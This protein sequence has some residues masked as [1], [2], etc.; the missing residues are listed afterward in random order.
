MW[1]LTQDKYTG[2]WATQIHTEQVDLESSYWSFHQLE[3]SLASTREKWPQDGVSLDSKDS[4]CAKPGAG[5][6]KGSCVGSKEG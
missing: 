5:D 3:Y 6:S 4:E 2:P 1:T